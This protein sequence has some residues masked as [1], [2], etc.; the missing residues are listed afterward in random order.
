MYSISS[1]RATA[2]DLR[3]TS[4]VGVGRHCVPGAA[5]SQFRHSHLQLAARDHF[6]D[7]EAVDRAFVAF[8]KAAAVH[9]HGVL[10]ADLLHTGL[11][12]CRG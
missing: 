9:Y 11:P 6:L 10:L 1:T 12:V 3:S 5:R 2:R 7:Q 8:L 4:V